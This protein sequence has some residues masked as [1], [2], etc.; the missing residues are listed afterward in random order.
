MSAHWLNRA[1]SVLAW[2]G[3]FVS[4][5]LTI[6][7]Y[8]NLTVPCA[9]GVAACEKV[10]N[11]PYSMLLGVPVAL[12]GLVGYTF[13]ILLAALRTYPAVDR[14][15]P[16][17]R[18]GLIVAALGTAFSIYLQ[19]TSFAI[20][21]A[22]CTWCI[23]SA[24]IMVLTLVLM[25]FLSQNDSLEELPGNSGDK[26]TFVGA[27]ALAV[28]G[29]GFMS[30]KAY[31]ATHGPGRTVDT[32]PDI[33][34]PQEYYY[35]GHKDAPVTIVEWAD[36]YCGA[37]RTTAPQVREFQRQ[38]KDRVRIAY[39]NYPIWDKP[40]HEFSLP[41]AMIAEYAAQKGKLW[42]FVD[43]MYSVQAEDIKTLNQVYSMAARVGLNVDEIRKR[44]EAEDDALL[45]PVLDS[46]KRGESNGVKETPTYIV[47][48]KGQAPILARNMNIMNIL[49]TPPI[50]DIVM[51]K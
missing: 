25:A 39:R 17:V 44:V 37:C 7:H 5:F 40:G 9:S 18:A 14:I 33:V 24:V 29:I 45:D 20:I 3:F 2:G 32:T 28:G 12:L 51:S 11:S 31:D 22:G 23:T 4:G 42:Q 36:F 47:F 48:A 49:T 30:W 19:Y 1:L 16:I 50:R 21:G 35:D 6:A 38:N 27:M 41:A 15:R 13:L 10:Q 34:V 26:G 43:L 46:I 8:W